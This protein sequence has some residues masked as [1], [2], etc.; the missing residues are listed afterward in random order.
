MFL[1]TVVTLLCV[2]GYFM[3]QMLPV[4]LSKPVPS[5]SN[6]EVNR[7]RVLLLPS[8]C[9]S[10]PDSAPLSLRFLS[11]FL[12]ITWFC[13]SDLHFTIHINRKPLTNIQI[14]SRNIHKDSKTPK[15]IKSQKGIISSV[16]SPKSVSSCFLF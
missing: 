9:F 6:P 3:Y 10:T 16:L 7:D 14:Y 15:G 12:F 5:P 8:G 4:L 2:L 11:L 1:I 13:N